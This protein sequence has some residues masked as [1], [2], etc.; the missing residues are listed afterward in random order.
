M[1]DQVKYDKGKRY[2]QPGDHHNLIAIAMFMIMVFHE[3]N[4]CWPNLRNFTASLPFLVILFN[5]P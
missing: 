3:W 4:V 2:N 5:K 1:P